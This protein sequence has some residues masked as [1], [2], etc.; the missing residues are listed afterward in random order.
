[1]NQKVNIVNFDLYKKDLFDRIYAKCGNGINY[2]KIKHKLDLLQDIYASD[3]NDWP[4]NA[5]M[6]AK[7][8]AVYTNNDY[9]KFDSSGKLLE[10]KKVRLTSFIATLRH[11]LIHVASNDKNFNG[12]LKNNS[13]DNFAMNEGATQALYEILFD[14]VKS[15]SS[16][17]Y[18]DYKKIVK[19]IVKTIGIPPLASSYF[20]HTNALETSCNKVANNNNFY[21]D[22]QEQLN[23]SIFL[24][25]APY[26]N[27]Y[28]RN[29]ALSLEQESMQNTYKYFLIN[30]VL[31]HLQTLSDTEKKDYL[32]D[33]LSVVQDDIDVENYLVDSL[34]QLI[35]KSSQE[36]QNFKNDLNHERKD[37]ELSKDL[38]FSPKKQEILVYDNGDV[39]FNSNK[40]N[41]KETS[42]EYLDFIYATINEEPPLTDSELNGIISNLKNNSL[43]IHFYANKSVLEA[44]KLWAKLKFELS[45]KGIYLLNDYEDI[46]T[47]GSLKPDFVTLE[48]GKPPSFEDLKKLYSKYQLVD[49]TTDKVVNRKTRTQLY[50]NHMAICASFANLWFD[51]YNKSRTNYTIN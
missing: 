2:A 40:I 4:P 34:K 37:I 45:N 9:Y 49:S 38:L 6:G 23:T 16:D 10:I 48:K 30:F 7:E 32:N 12:L 13:M 35:E 14:D 31:P 42:P 22:L 25:V 21:N 29:I 3:M 27:E 5:I 18:R 47:N 15:P 8:N 41:A 36:I 51:N 19:M 24:R 26:P 1:M 46:P 44:R 11:E 39:Y 33:L 28:I 17:A 43:Y 20:D 50:N